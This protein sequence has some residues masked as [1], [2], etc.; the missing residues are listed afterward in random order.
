MTTTENRVHGRVSA[1]AAWG[2]FAILLVAFAVFESVK[3]GG[4]TWLVLVIGLVGP[5]LAMVAGIGQ[6]HARGQL[7]ARAVRLYNLV[8]QALLPLALLAAVTVLPLPDPVLPFTLGL[9]WLAHIAIDR[10]CGYG[11]RTAQGWLRA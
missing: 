2:V 6:P 3:Y 4:A 11:L 10:A 1:R 8:H 7:P 9:A 5:D